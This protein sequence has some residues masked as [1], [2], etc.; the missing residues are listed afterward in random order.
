MEIQET[1]STGLCVRR[2][3]RKISDS[4]VS[5][6]SL[7]MKIL[8]LAVLAMFANVGSADA[9]LEAIWKLSGPTFKVVTPALEFCPWERGSNDGE[10]KGVLCGLSLPLSPKADHGLKTQEL[11]F[12][13]RF[14]LGLGTSFH[15]GNIPPGAEDD[16]DLLIIEPT[17]IFVKSFKDSRYQFVPELGVGFYRFSGR[18]FENFTRDATIVGALFRRRLGNSR[19][20]LQFGLR[21]RYFDESFTN[22]DFGGTPEPQSNGGEWVGSSQIG[23]HIEFWGDATKKKRKEQQNQSRKDTVP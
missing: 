14:R 7:A 13:P 4:N 16:I 6:Q 22:Q 11:G 10:R 20:Q 15:T 18:G 3:E 17:F 9:I 2:R 19:Y 5:R 8:P 1:G 12:K 23:V 21:A